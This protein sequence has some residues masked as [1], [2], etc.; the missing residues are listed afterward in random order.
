MLSFRWTWLFYV[1]DNTNRKTN[2]ELRNTIFYC[3]KKINLV[4][5]ENLFI[6]KTLYPTVK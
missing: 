6:N 1:K 5:S 3:E 4:N 2:S